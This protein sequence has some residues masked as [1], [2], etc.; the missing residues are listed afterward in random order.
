M[1]PTKLMNRFR[2]WA[3]TLAIVFCVSPAF[4][5][6]D[7]PWFHSTDPLAQRDEWGLLT[8][9]PLNPTDFERREH[10]RLFYYSQPGTVLANDPAYV[11]A[12][13]VGLRRKGYYNGPIDGVFSIDVRAAICRL[14]KAHAMRVTGNL[15]VPVRR[16]LYLP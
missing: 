6:E 12:V 8:Q 16:V 2:V 11:G 3:A 14:Q 5:L 4:A 13:Q 10:W 9:G 1:L 15:S 7:A